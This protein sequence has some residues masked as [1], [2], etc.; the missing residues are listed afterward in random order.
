MSRNGGG[1]LQQ[2]PGSPFLTG[3]AGTQYAGV[4][5]GPQDSDQ[6]I[7]TNPDHSLLFAVNSGSDT[8][9]VFHVEANGALSPVEGSPFSSGGNDPVSLDLVGNTLFVV[10][11]SGDPGRPSAILPNYTTLRVQPNGSLVPA[12][13][14]TNDTAHFFQ[15]TVSVGAGASPSQAH[16][17]PNTNLL[18]GADFLGGL[19]QRFVFDWNGSLLQL[20]PLA[21]PSSAFSDTTTP[22]LPLGIWHHPK[23]PLLYVGFVTDNKL[24]VYRIDRLGGLEFVRTVPNSGQAICWIRPNRAGTRL[25]TTDTTTNSIGVYDLTNPEEPVQIQEFQLSGVGNVLQFSLSSEDK[26]LYA[27]SSRGSTAIPEGQGNVLHALK[28]HRDGTLTETLSPVVFQLPIDTRPQ[29]VAV[30]PAD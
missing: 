3:G 25:Y 14:S 29:G 28:V 9:A 27:L 16:V 8:I 15:A 12:G 11:K 22:R 7:I 2:V 21:L 17:V 13:S 6:D 5:V 10:N 4:N 18:F 24:G 23:L 1:Q 19:I 26:F 30:V 20:P